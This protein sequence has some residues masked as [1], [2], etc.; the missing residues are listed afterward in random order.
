[1]DSPM[2]TGLGTSETGAPQQASFFL[3]E[4]PLLHGV[5][6]NS[7][8]WR[9]LPRRPNIWRSPK[10][11]RRLSGYKGYLE[12]CNFRTE[13]LPQPSMATTREALT[14]PIILYFTVGPNTSKSATISFARKCSQVKYVCSTCPRVTNWPISLPRP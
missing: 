12:S 14:S 6:E 11:P 9:C 8:Q 5:V 10:G 7:Q 2:P 4:A 13:I 3:L 1:M